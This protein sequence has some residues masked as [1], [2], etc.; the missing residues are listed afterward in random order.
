MQSPKG[1]AGPV[2]LTPGPVMTSARVRDAAY[3]SLLSHRDPAFVALLD[4]AALGLTS[5]AGASHHDAILLAGGGTSA[6][7]AALATFA[8]PDKPLLVV[9]NGAF[10]ERIATIASA[11]RLPV[12]HLALPWGAPIPLDRVADALERT[13]ASAVAAV[14][15]ETSTAVLNPVQQIGELAHRA[16]AHFFVDVVSSLGAEEFDASRAHASV[17]IG[18][19][20]KC[21]HGIAG[22]S[23]VLAD[24]ALWSHARTLTPATLY[25]DLK[26]YSLT[27]GGTRVP[28]TPP[29]SAI[30]GLA[31]A[32]RELA[33]EGGVS[34]RRACYQERHS[35][36]ERNL[37]QLGIEQCYPGGGVCSLTVARIPE[38]HT[39][40]S[41]YSA[42]AREGF[43]VYQ[44]KG[45]L[46][47]RAFLIA[48]MG[49][50]ALD[51]FGAFFRALGG[52]MS[53][54]EPHER[55]ELA[56]L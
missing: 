5:I 39:S 15:H 22:V 49:A 44:A 37:I 18:S 34:A 21:L 1:N 9:S 53:K 27:A 4:E 7:E 28:F 38:G 29:I 30:A 26:N 48:N 19:A 20:N 24:R 11:L 46:R 8:S 23:F 47:E 32:L 43:V 2:L 33:D 41:L 50:L 55:V 17:V 45:G 10:G 14:H 52:V 42:L 31:E 36:V 40:D 13:R 56:D 35:R 3:S 6:T 16:S 54:A 25:F 51:V 12:H